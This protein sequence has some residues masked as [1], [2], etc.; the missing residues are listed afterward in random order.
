MP[1]STTKLP[2]SD[3]LDAFRSRVSAGLSNAGWT[4]T[5]VWA[6]QAP[7]D[8][9]LPLATASIEDMSPSELAKDKDTS[10]VASFVAGRLWSLDHQEVEDGANQ[11]V[12]SVTDHTNDFTV[13][14]WQIHVVRINAVVPLHSRRSDGPPLFG[15]S[16]QFE[17]HLEPTP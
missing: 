15:K 10:P 17:F 8:E 14:G 3:L 7:N 2:D 4:N 12:Q 11:V 13:V 6:F 9:D 1:R 16:I 5:D